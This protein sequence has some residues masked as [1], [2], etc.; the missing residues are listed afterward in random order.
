MIKVL[1]ALA[2]ATL[3]LAS[4]GDKKT[5]PKETTPTTVQEVKTGSLKIAFYHQDSM[6]SQFKYYKEQDEY[7][8]GKG[9][10]FQNEIDRL[11]KN[12]QDYVQRNQKKA[13][14]GLLSQDQ[15]E[16]IGAKAQGMENNIMQYKQ[17]NGQSLESETIERL[18]KIGKKIDAYSNEFC[19]KNN[20][21]ILIIQAPGGQIGYITPTM[22]VTSEFIEYLN[23]QEE[24]IQADIA[25]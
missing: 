21:D 6:K 25:E 8:Q 20:I 2:I 24:A 23:A 7:I 16:G 3:S 14:Q 13:Q 11:T 12:Y 15:L 17:T 1:A 5:E 22:D 4:C 9:K 19:A 18:E 10:K